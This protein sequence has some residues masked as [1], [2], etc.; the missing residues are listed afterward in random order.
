MYLNYNENPMHSYD[1]QGNGYVTT[2]EPQ[3]ISSPLR[4]LSDSLETMVNPMQDII[5]SLCGLTST[6][7]NGLKEK[8]GV[9]EMNYNKIIDLYVSKSKENIKAKFEKEKEEIINKDEIVIDIKNTE[10]LCNKALKELSE[11]Y[12]LIAE[13]TLKI[14]S[15]YETYYTKE[16]KEKLANLDVKYSKDMLELSNL[17]TELRAKLELYEKSDD[18]IDDL[19]TYGILNKQGKLDIK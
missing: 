14:P 3:T 18:V 6:Q 15:I 5:N 11:K 12:E 13:S 17:V 19:R 7:I 9:K 4:D 10:E 2:W 16:T 1:M 8:E